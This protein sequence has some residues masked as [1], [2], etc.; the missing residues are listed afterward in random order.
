MGASIALLWTPA[1]GDKTRQRIGR[2][3]RGLRGDEDVWDELAAE[4]ERAASDTEE[5]VEEL[6]EAL[7]T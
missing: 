5:E 6:A 3:M 2:R 4:L 7:K 1:S